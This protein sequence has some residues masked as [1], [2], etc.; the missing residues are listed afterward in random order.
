M[1]TAVPV[2]SRHPADI[3]GPSSPQQG[4]HRCFLRILISIGL[5]P[6]YR[7]CHSQSELLDSCINQQE[8]LSSFFILSI[9]VWNVRR[10]KKSKNLKEERNPEVQ[11]KG[12]EISDAFSKWRG[13]VRHLLPP[14]P[15]HF[16]PPL[17]SF[18]L[19]PSQLNTSKTPL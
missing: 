6:I 3:S 13:R 10:K 14:R 19:F 8:I 11:K 5:F 15:P 4:V 9:F 16:I 17:N 2:S 18:M 1:R 12:R 7:G